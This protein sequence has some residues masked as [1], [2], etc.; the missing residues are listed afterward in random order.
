MLITLAIAQKSITFT[1]IY[2]HWGPDR[3]DDEWC[4]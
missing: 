3:D 4:L 2:F 1:N